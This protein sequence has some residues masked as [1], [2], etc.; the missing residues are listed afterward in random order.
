MTIPI[1]II[2]ILI[3]IL[4][5]YLTTV[6][7]KP[8]REQ[9]RKAKRLEEYF[10]NQDDELESSRFRYDADAEQRRASARDMYRANHYLELL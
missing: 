7:I 9:K 2:R 4:W 10:Q 1:S 8:S 5:Y 3:R 6:V